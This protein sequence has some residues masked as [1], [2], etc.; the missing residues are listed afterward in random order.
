M[1]LDKVDLCFNK[2]WINNEMNAGSRIID[3][4]EPLGMPPSS[5]YNMERGQV[6]GYWNYFQD[7]Q[8]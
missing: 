8:P 1:T 6:D 2:R 5:F 3:I 7:F 4:G